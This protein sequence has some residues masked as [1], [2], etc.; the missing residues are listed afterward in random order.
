MHAWKPGC[1]CKCFLVLSFVSVVAILL[2]DVFVEKTVSRVSQLGKV[3]RLSRLSRVSRLSRKSKGY[4]KAKY[5]SK[6]PEITLLLRMPGKVQEQRKRFFCDFF[7]TTVLFWP[8]SYGKIVLVLDEESE[9]DHEFGEIIPNHIRARFPDYELEVLYEALPKDE[10][11]LEFQRAPRDAGYNRQL[12]SS[13][14]FDLYTND[15]IIGWMDS[16]AAFITPVT[17][18]MIFSGKRLRVLGWDCTFD[19]VWVKQWA[20][21]TQRALGLPYVA[22]YMSYF[23]VYIYR[24]TFLHCRE[25]IMKHLKVS[26]FEQAFQLFYHDKNML[27]PVSVVLS[28]AWYFERDRYDWNMKLCTGLIEYNKRFPP[29]ASIGPEHLEDILSQPQATFHVPYGEFLSYN[30]LVSFCLSHKAAGN[31]LDICLKHKFE[32]SHSFDLLHHDLQRVRTIRPNPCSGKKAFCLGVLRHH[33]KEVGH[34]VIAKRRKLDW[35]SVQTAEKLA[36]RYGITC[37]PLLY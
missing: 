26:D 12:W 6:D 14:F 2:K 15:P 35:S 16:D 36:E 7:R 22:D 34:E 23:P 13:F 19:F 11:V 28:Y 24:D 20:L 25:Y 31:K 8:P 4:S 29:A 10:N 30:I 32:L 1:L 5:E 9:M 37:K 18:S 3:S 21:T 17:K 33:Y 27:S